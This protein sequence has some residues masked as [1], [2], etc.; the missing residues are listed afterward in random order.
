MTDTSA[1][2]K[3]IWVAPE[4]KS[5]DIDETNRA[6]RRGGDGNAIYVDCTRS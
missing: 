1:V 5:L 2:R 3:E 4:I 6:S